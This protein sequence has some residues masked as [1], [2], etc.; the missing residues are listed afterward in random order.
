MRGLYLFMERRSGA[1]SSFST[2]HSDPLPREIVS[3]SLFPFF[4]RS[5]WTGTAIYFSFLSFFFPFFLSPFYFWKMKISG[6]NYRLIANIDD[7]ILYRYEVRKG[8]HKKRNLSALRTMANC[9]LSQPLFFII[10]KLSSQSKNC[11]K[12]WILSLDRDS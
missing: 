12:R 1:N 7:L 11:I 4:P 9:L 2:L 5:L 3:F 10:P 8:F 6:G